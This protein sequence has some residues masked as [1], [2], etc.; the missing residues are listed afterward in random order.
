MEKLIIK[1]RKSSATNADWENIKDS[2]SACDS[3]FKAMQELFKKY[4]K[5]YYSDYF[6]LEYSIELFKNMKSLDEVH[7]FI[8]NEVL[9]NNYVDWE[10]VY[11][12]EF[13]KSLEPWIPSY[14]TDDKFKQNFL[15]EVKK[16]CLA[17]H[18]DWVAEHRN[19]S[20]EVLNKADKIKF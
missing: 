19:I 2:L 6:N 1:T 8:H 18:S 20:K 10:A 12:P 3:D 14:V 16:N 5:K 11:I 13:F 15:E 17:Y 7:N 4:E 9:K